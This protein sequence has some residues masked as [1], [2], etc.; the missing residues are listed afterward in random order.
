MNLAA[1]HIQPL[2]LDLRCNTPGDVTRDHI[3]SA[4]ERGLPTISWQAEHATPALVI[5]GGPSLL[6]T[7][8]TVKLGQAYNGVIFALNGAARF[9]NEHG[10]IPHYQVILDAREKNV[11]LLGEAQVYLLAAQ[12]HPKMFDALEG[13]KV[14]IF[15][16]I[17]VEGVPN[18]R[19][20]GCCHTVGLTSLNLVHVMGFRE[21]HLFGYDSSF[22]E[23]HH[24]YHQEQT[25]KEAQTVEVKVFDAQGQVREFVTNAVMAKQAEM[26]PQVTERLTDDG[27]QIMVHGTGLL[28]TI[29]HAMRRN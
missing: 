5:G 21:V 11:D 15:H 26:F 4:L 6:Q 22:T 1:L 20:L 7:L 16:T 8:P 14:G 23:D 13:K 9:L 24:A 2:Q 25:E 29:A 17:P 3:F 28:P 19:V 18:D 12:C 27:A 10:I